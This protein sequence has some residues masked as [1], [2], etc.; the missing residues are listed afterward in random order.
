MEAYPESREWIEGY[1]Y[2]ALMSLLGTPEI[3]YDTWAVVTYPDQMYWFDYEGYMIGQDYYNIL[4]G[5]GV[6]SGGAAAIT[7]IS[8]DDRDVNWE[9]GSGKL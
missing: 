5:I 6:L 7:D 1:P 4:E 3:D 8:F 2:I 9:E